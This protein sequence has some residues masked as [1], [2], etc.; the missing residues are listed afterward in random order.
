MALTMACK[1]APSDSQGIILVGD[2]EAR[3]TK[4]FF[5]S[6]PSGTI[7]SWDANNPT[8]TV[9]WQTGK[10]GSTSYVFIASDSLT[11]NQVADIA[12]SLH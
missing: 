4:G 2:K 3:W 7:P 6:G 9:S 1:D 10:E 8:V 11:L 12:R 5:A